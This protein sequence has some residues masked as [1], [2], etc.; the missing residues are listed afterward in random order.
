MLCA[1]CENEE[2][3]VVARFENVAYVLCETCALFLEQ[4]IE[5]K[6]N[7]RENS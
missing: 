2:G 4:M 7:G 6:E 5:N 1:N 3:V